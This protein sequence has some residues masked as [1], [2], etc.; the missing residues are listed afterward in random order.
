MPIPHQFIPGYNAGRDDIV[1]AKGGGR[2]RLSTLQARSEAAADPSLARVIVKK[3]GGIELEGGSMLGMGGV[4]AHVALLRQLDFNVPII[5]TR[6]KN[7]KT[8]IYGFR[9]G[10]V[11]NASN[12]LSNALKIA[13][14]SQIAAICAGQFDSN[15]LYVQNNSRFDFYR[16]SN[17][18]LASMDLGNTNVVKGFSSLLFGDELQRILP[19]LSPW[20]LGASQALGLDIRNEGSTSLYHDLVVYAL[21]P[22]DCPDL[23]EGEYDLFL[24]CIRWNSTTDWTGNFGNLK[25][26][27]FQTP[28]GAYLLGMLG[29]AEGVNAG[30]T[31]TATEIHVETIHGGTG[32]TIV[33][34]GSGKWVPDQLVFGAQGDRILALPSLQYFEENAGLTVELNNDIASAPSAFAYEFYVYYLAPSVRGATRPGP[35]QQ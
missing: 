26:Y 14:K 28:G 23:P 2:V 8:A 30:I 1:E 16:S 34:A 18:H 31:H 6:T 19:F 35:D 25:Q 21:E 13:T 4:P 29:H 10:S 7:V 32:N 3:G 5:P 15:A 27:T 12:S 33:G 22:Y 17:Y 11:A 9:V 20:E 24:G